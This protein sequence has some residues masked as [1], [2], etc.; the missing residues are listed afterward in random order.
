MSSAPAL[1]FLLHESM[2]HGKY[3]WKREYL[4]LS[5]GKRLRL[6]KVVE[7]ED[8]TIY[9]PTGLAFGLPFGCV[10][11]T[12][13]EYTQALL[14][15]RKDA[16]T[17]K[18]QAELERQQRKEADQKLAGVRGLASSPKLTG[19]RTLPHADVVPG[20]SLFDDFTIVD[21]EYQGDYLLEVAAIRYKNWQ[22]VDRY[23]S[24]VHF[25]EWLWPKTTELTRIT[26][27]QLAKGTPEAKVLQAFSKLAEG[28]LLIAHN[29]GA[30]R[31]KFEKACMRQG[32]EMLPNKWFCTLALA[33]ARLPKGTKCGLTELCD[34]FKF[35]NK[36]AHRAMSDVERTLKV[37]LHFYQEDPIT[38][39]DPKARKAALQFFPA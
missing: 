7:F 12:K 38:T 9:R 31:S 37:L 30:D 8:K 14:R 20:T 4:K 28:S 10:R 25:T 26:A 21:T 27:Q 11:S 23:E 6:E 29:I 16:A 3:S 5:L 32:L 18:L 39:L 1:Y 22:E 35:G 13:L 2:S 33:R 19:P 24:L 34:R 17:R 36:G 15:F